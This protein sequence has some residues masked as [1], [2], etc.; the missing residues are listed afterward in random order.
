MS[1][2]SQKQALLDAVS[3]LRSA[4]QLLLQATRAMSDPAKLI[5]ANTEY[6]HLDSCLSQMFHAQA[7]ADDAT[8]DSAVTVL[9]QRS[10]TL[11]AD[12]DAINAI[13]KDVAVGAKIIGYV[14]KAAQI[15]AAL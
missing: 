2:S 9:K 11:Q 15:I 1:T 3:Q 6:T 10:A 5:Q 12:A 13:I 8:F 7:L 14:T 4:E